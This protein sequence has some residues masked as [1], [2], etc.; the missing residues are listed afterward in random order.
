MRGHVNRDISVNVIVISGPC[1]K[2]I[3]AIV[4]EALLGGILKSPLYMDAVDVQGPRWKEKIAREK[5]GRRKV[6]EKEGGKEGE[7]SRYRMYGLRSH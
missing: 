2:G 5:E 1:M 3:L 4:W 6:G 7:G